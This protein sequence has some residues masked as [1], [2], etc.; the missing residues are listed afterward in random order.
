M[1]N[2]PPKKYPDYPALYADYQRLQSSGKN[3]KILRLSNGKY[4]ELFDQ[5]DVQQIGNALV[6]IRALKIVKLLHSDLAANRWP[7]NTSVTRFL[8]VDSMAGS[9]SMLTPYQ[10]ASNRPIDGIDLEG[11]EYLTYTININLGKT[12]GRPSPKSLGLAGD[13]TLVGAISSS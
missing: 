11:L 5:S 2:P 13:V 3:G 8:S 12:T 7:D 4:D 9:F 10:Y 6:N 1:G